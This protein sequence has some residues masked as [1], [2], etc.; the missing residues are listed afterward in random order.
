MSPTEDDLRSALSEGAGDVPDAGHIAFV[1]RETRARRRKRVLSAAA[2]VIVVG[3]VATGGT[4]LAQNSGSSENAGSG[5]NADNVASAGTADGGGGSASGPAVV[6]SAYG[7]RSSGSTTSGATAGGSGVVCPA[8]AGT[9]GLPAG[10]ST[11]GG[12]TTDKLFAQPVRTLTVCS[13]P[14]ASGSTAQ[15]TLAGSDATTLADSLENASTT[16][17]RGMCSDLRQADQRTL[18][19]I[20]TTADGKTL[21][22]VTTT[23]NEPRCAV[24]VS[25]GSAVRYDWA[26]PSTLSSQLARLSAGSGSSVGELPGSTVSTPGHAV[27]SPVH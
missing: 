19:I 17:Y 24:V 7:P 2:A 8:G 26:W 14:S 13:Y 22:T 10:G 12:G 15:L 5:G 16:P 11:A 23:I 9:S 25:N 27:G 1:A 20:A 4:L 18:E 21:P 3:G 6:P